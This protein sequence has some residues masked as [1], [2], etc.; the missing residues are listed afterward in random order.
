MC[1]RVCVCVIAYVCVWC[2]QM[3]D[4][5][6]KQERR[7]AAREKEH[8]L[9]GLPRWLSIR[10]FC[11]GTPIAEDILK[12][13]RTADLPW[14]NA[15]RSHLIHVCMRPT[16]MHHHTTA[17][18]PRT[19][20][21]ITLFRPLYTVILATLQDPSNHFHSN[22]LYVKILSNSRQQMMR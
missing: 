18:T 3:R 8:Y 7:M 2:S 17:H 15:R 10:Q 11:Q 9:Q 22:I 21:T 4:G 19:A 6:S 16:R 13:W 5:S 1:A 12:Y 14:G 20:H